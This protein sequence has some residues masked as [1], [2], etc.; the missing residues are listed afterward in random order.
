MCRVQS[1]FT[2]KY[3]NQSF[4]GLYVFIDGELYVKGQCKC[5]YWLVKSSCLNQTFY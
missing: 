5:C 4:Q 3:C 2:C 1:G